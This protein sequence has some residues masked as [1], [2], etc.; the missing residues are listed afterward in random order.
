MGSDIRVKF[1]VG[2]SGRYISHLD[3]LR[4]MERAIRRAKLPIS[5]SQGFH[6]SPK[7][8]FAS[9]LPVGITSEAEYVDLQMQHQIVTTKVIS[10]LND[11][12]PEG[13]SVKAAALLPSK[14]Q[15]L[16]SIVAAARYQLT[17]FESSQDLASKIVRILA[18]DELVVTVKHKKKLKQK[19]I[20]SLIYCL[21][22]D[23]KM[24]CVLLECASG[25]NGNLRPMDILKWLD[26]SLKDVVIHRTALLVKHK[27][28]GWIT[29]LDV[30]GV[31]FK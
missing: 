30:K 5:Y 12:L 20:R 29:P 6:P 4:T 8:S 23:S 7:M 25:I 1:S 19:D 27:D 11:M 24:N 22:Y 28:G 21:Q 16:M 26:L 17:I 14:Y 3:I 13:F 18:A 9:A 2:E 10:S 31:K 15:A